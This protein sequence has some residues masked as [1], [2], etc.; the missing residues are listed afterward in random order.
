MKR[1]AL[2]MVL[3]ILTGCGGSKV[4]T[5][6]MN[7]STHRGMDLNL[8][9]FNSNFEREYYDDIRLRQFDGFVVDY[10]QKK[11]QERS[12]AF[13]YTFD[14]TDLTNLRNSLLLSLKE[15]NHYA[16]VRDI[17]LKQTTNMPNGLQ[18]FID[19]ERMGVSQKISFIVEIVGE[20]KVIDGS[21]NELGHR[22]I[23]VKEKGV[24]TLSAG[25]NKAINKFIKEVESLLNDSSN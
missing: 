16:N 23:H 2:L 25:K 1:L 4:S 21:G 22:A 8:M 24:M 14:E 12:K 10:I 7:L 11:I 20:I 5:T 3:F 19:F 9:P 17:N 18:L 15:T 6:K 13:T